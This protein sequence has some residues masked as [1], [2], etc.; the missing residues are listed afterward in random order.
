MDGDASGAGLSFSECADS[1]G[2]SWQPKQYV[3]TKNTFFS[4][5][6]D[7]LVGELATITDPAPVSPFYFGL[8]L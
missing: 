5:M 8:V 7:L 2:V 4:T 3:L 6:A 1:A